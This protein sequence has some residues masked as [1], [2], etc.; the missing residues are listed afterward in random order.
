LIR[1]ACCLL[2]ISA[3]VVIVSG[4]TKRHKPPTQVDVKG[5]VNLDGKPMPDGEISFFVLGEVPTSMPIQSGAFSGKAAVGSN[6]V[7]V[8][9][10]KAGTPVDMGG[11]KFGGEKENY[12]P[13]EYNTASKMTADVA[14]GGANDFKF[15]VKSK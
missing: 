4:C 14:S 5:T 12:I 6:R 7:E 15:D 9:A 8:R 10:Y 3:T 13:A 11:Q 2:L 1:S